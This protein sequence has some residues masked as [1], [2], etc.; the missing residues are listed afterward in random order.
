VGGVRGD[1]PKGI[2]VNDEPIPAESTVEPAEPPRHAPDP[3]PPSR[4]R[5]PTEVVPPFLEDVTEPHDIGMRRVR[6]RLWNDRAV[7]DALQWLS[8]YYTDVGVSYPR[9]PDGTPDRRPG[10]GTIVG[11]GERL[12]DQVKGE[13]VLLSGAIKTVIEEWKSPDRTVARHKSSVIRGDAS[14]GQPDYRVY[15]SLRIRG[16][17]TVMTELFLPVGTPGWAAVENLEATIG[18]LL[19]AM[20]ADPVY[21]YRPSA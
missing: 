4:F 17:P 16:R 9:N 2:R 8:R 7:G 13:W 20:A 19:Q 1:E 5:R 10:G 6:C 21:E 15:A 3:P 14:R 18:G 12:F 11:T